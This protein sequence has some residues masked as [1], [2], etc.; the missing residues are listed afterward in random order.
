MS[1]DD[2]EQPPTDAESSPAD[3]FALVGHEIRAEI[4]EVLG[5]S[6]ELT[7][8]EL[9]SRLDADV[10]SSHL[11]YHLQRLVGHHVEKT[12]EGYQ[13]R[14]AGSRFYRALSAGT[15]DRHEEYMTVDANF[16][17]SSCQ[18]EVEAIFDRGGVRFVCPDC[19]RS[20]IVDD[21]DIP[22][23]AFEDEE[24]AFAHFR[25]YMVLKLFSLARG[26]CPNCE[27]QSRKELHTREED[28]E[29]DN[30]SAVGACDLCDTRWSLSVWMAVHAD[31]GF[32]A[33][34]Q[35]HGVDAISTPYWELFAMTD[36]HTTVRS[37]DP[38]E[39]TLRVTFDDDTLEVVVDDELTVIER[40]RVDGTESGDPWL[41]PGVQSAVQLMGS[42]ESGDEVILPDNATCVEYIRRHRWPDGVVCPHCISPNTIKKGTTGKD[43]QRYRCQD[44]ERI[45][46]DL[47]GTL[48]ADYG[49]SLP[50]M[51]YIIRE[52][53]ATDAAE[54]AQQLDRSYQTIRDF[55]HDIQ[56]A[57]ANAS[58]ATTFAA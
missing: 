4:I 30:I 54:L 45:F 15:F 44:C 10:D 17:C 37:T 31:P 52:Q 55:I 36:N 39:L 57:L 27:N 8:S 53:E 43:A 18:A 22:L 46:N 9:R 5:A 1:E 35:E 40:N 42:M 49:L 21:L 38:L 2:P 56:D 58:D 25:Q 6:G 32:I 29:F 48:F 47:S 12:D 14:A 11:H 16:D 24:A 13:L 28:P 7:L 51:F 20:Y 19:G 23:T 50:E 3:A 33:F 41:V 26:V 34:S